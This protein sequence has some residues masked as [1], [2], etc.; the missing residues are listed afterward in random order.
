MDSN[1]QDSEKLRQARAFTFGN[2]KTRRLIAKK[3]KFIKRGL[4][5]EANEEARMIRHDA[6][7]QSQSVEPTTGAINLMNKLDGEL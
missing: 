1:M 7:Q 5:K 3:N 2:R 4:W 6:V